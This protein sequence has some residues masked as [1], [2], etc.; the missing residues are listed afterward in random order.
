MTSGRRILVATPDANIR[1]AVRCA[2]DADD[3]VKTIDVRSTA[4]V[5]AVCRPDLIVLDAL[6]R[7]L[8]MLIV[9]TLRNDF[10]TVLTPILFVVSSTPTDGS[11]DLAAGDDYVLRTADPQEFAMRVRMSLQRAARLRGIHPLTGLP[12]NTSVTGEIAARQIRGVPFSCLYIDL[13]DFKAFND[14][15]GFV[16]GD[17]VIL[18]VTRCI[19]RVLSARPPGEC[20]AGHVGGDDFVVLT[21][22]ALAVETAAGIVDAFNAQGHGCAVSI[23][24]VER[25]DG[26]GDPAEVARAAAAAK[27]SAKRRPDR[28]A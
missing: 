26:F 12:G 17:H 3:V 16:R 14:E 20:F 15:H 23:G 7:P 22:P 27:V 19:D 28:P 8:A 9:A 11:L 21:P 18:A 5:A 1:S 24:V 13:D 10:R 6:D 2:L 4:V 25:A